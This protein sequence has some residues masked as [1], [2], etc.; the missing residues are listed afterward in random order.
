M[1]FFVL[2]RID[3]NEEDVKVLDVVAPIFMLVLFSMLALQGNN[4]IDTTTGEAVQL[5]FVV[6]INYG[7]MV[8]ALIPSFLNVFKFFHKQVSG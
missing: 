1:L 2:F 6:W 3:I 4:V 7:M 8:F 5:I